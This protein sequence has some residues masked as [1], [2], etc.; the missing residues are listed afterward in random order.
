M[1]RTPEAS[2]IP[3]LLIE[4]AAAH[5]DAE[6]VVDSEVRWTYDELHAQVR[7]VVAALVETGVRPGERVALWGRNGHRWIAAALGVLSAGA[8]LVPVNTRYKGAEAH[9]LLQRS[10]TRLLLVDDGFLGNDYSGMLRA[11]AGTAELPEMVA[12]SEGTEL[13]SWQSFLDRGVRTPEAQVTERFR[14]VRPDDPSD[15][16]FTS[17]TTG[18]PK[19][20]LT[21][22]A[23]NIRAYD[24]W[25]RR[26]GLRTGDRY[27]IVNPMFHSFGYKAGVLACL[28][29]GATML[30]EAVLDVPRVLR[31]VSEE[32]VTVLPGPPALYT[33]MLDHPERG[34]ADFSSL[35][36]AVTGASTVPIALVER[37]RAEMFPT[38][39]TAYGLTESCGVVT[40]CVHSDEDRVVAETAGS[41][42]EGVEVEISAP[43]GTRLPAGETGEVL[44][45]GYNVMRGYYADPESTAAAVGSDGWLHT[46]DVGRLDER[47]NLTI[48]DRLKDMFV[49]GGFN[50][51]PAEIEQVLGGHP[52]I[53]ESAVVGVPDERLGEVGRAHVVARPGSELTAE[54][55]I[56]HCR[57]RLANFKVPRQVVLVDELPRNAGGKV[58]KNKLR[59]Q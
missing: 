24:A 33:S 26:T 6:A 51:Y 8:V 15:M 35:R 40:T 21:E 28:V 3:A 4:T 18:Q 30:P 16:L 43:D 54:Q 14:A 9:S 22:H 57:E 39:L 31:R 10:G 1:S 52:G 44:V 41:A 42:I 11:A 20:A 13:P 36:L 50:A 59:E 19:G 27:L 53:A 47:G 56:A 58:L 34:D 29:R 7:K 17:G 49:V 37:L 23:Q 46:G 45:R 12:M 25:G 2:T 48:T 32:H 55:A 38:V 5:G